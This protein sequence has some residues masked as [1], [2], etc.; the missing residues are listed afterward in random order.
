M[1]V[2]LVNKKIRIKKDANNNI[3]RYNS[4]SLKQY[5]LKIYQTQVTGINREASFDERLDL[6]K[7]RLLKH[8]LKS[9]K[10]NVNTTELK[11]KL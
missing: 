5:G 2:N 11:K 10:L 9:N 4:N 6:Q 7:M 8:N 3:T 1:L